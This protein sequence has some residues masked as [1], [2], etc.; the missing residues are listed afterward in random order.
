MRIYLKSINHKFF[1]RKA[2][3]GRL[4]ISDSEL[5]ILIEDRKFSVRNPILSESNNGAFQVLGDLGSKSG[6]DHT[7]ANFVLECEDA[8][9]L[10]DLLWFI[11]RDSKMDTRTKKYLAKKY[12][13]DAFSA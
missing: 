2:Y 11:A 9:D 5:T 6:T 13:A 1:T 10:K 3:L 7:P 12:L 4:S 8:R